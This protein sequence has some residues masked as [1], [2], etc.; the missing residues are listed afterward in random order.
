LNLKNCN[1]KHGLTNSLNVLT[2]LC[3]FKS[4]VF[5]NLKIAVYVI[6]SIEKVTEVPV[7]SVP[8]LEKFSHFD[9]AMPYLLYYLFQLDAW[10]NKEL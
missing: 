10:G 4:T 1:L 8:V 5:A 2:W 7:I 9:Y 3:D 6:P